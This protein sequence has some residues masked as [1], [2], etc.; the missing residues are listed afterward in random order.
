MGVISGIVTKNGYP[1]KGARV[2]ASVGGTFDG[3]VTKD[4][5]TDD[6]GRFVL[7]WGSD[8]DAHKIF[9]YGSEVMRDVRN[10]CDNVHIAL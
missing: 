4:V 6:Q 2:S 8:T 7:Q 1:I 9:C 10:G 5:Y 3:G